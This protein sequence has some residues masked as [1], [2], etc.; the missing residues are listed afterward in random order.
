M[1]TT[2]IYGTRRQQVTTRSGAVLERQYV[3][4]PAETWEALRMLCITQH[5]SGSQIIGSLIDI[6]S[7]HVGNPTEK[8]NEQA[9][10]RTN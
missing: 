8:R 5:R 9:D 10:S 4:L 2:S 1:Y 7:A 6:A 3:F